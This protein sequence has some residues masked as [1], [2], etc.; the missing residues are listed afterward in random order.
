[1]LGSDQTQVVASERWTALEQT[2]RLDTFVSEVRRIAAG[3]GRDGL[4]KTGNGQEDLD[5]RLLL[6]IIN[7]T[8]EYRAAETL[9]VKGNVVAPPAILGLGGAWSFRLQLAPAAKDDVFAFREASGEW[10]EIC[11]AWGFKV[12]KGLLGTARWARGKIEGLAVEGV[13][14]ARDGEGELILGR[15]KRKYQG[16]ETRDAADIDTD[17]LAAVASVSDRISLRLQHRTHGQLSI[18]S[19]TP[20]SRWHRLRTA[21]K[22]FLQWLIGWPRWFTRATACFT[23]RPSRS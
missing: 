9:K 23:T 22:H 19:A 21:D 3:E 16:A 12:A 17:P 11:G 7:G 1:M 5:R 6:D 8:A 14:L 15:V 13:Q 2:P 18:R 20:H 4:L 10:K